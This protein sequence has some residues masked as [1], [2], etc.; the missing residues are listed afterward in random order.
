MDV[1]KIP[2]LKVIHAFGNNN[3][4]LFAPSFEIYLSTPG[5]NPVIHTIGFNA[6]LKANCMLKKLFICV[7]KPAGF[8]HPIKQSLFMSYFPQYPHDNNDNNLF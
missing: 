3:Q 4:Q 5:Q 7:H 2:S 8:K 6:Y 1:K